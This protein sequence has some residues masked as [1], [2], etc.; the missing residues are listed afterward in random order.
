MA[1]VTADYSSLPGYV[2]NTFDDKVVKLLK[3]GAI[4]FMP[5]DTIY[6]L[7]CRALDEAAVG[8]LHFVKKARLWQTLHCSNLGLGAA[9]RFRYQSFAGANHAAL[10]AG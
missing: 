1:V 3:S 10:L 4:G 9:Q 8:R 2:T 6:G 5:S 7:S